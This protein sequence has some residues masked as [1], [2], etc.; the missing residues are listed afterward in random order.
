M[1]LVVNYVFW[2]YSE[3]FYEISHSN[4]FMHIIK[5]QKIPTEFGGH[6]SPPLNSSKYFLPFLK[7]YNTL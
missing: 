2:P 6:L 1:Q 7:R 5:A 3:L 4:K